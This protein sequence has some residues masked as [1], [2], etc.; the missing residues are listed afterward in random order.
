MH[1]K[2]WH[3]YQHFKDRTP[4]WIKLYRYL[5]DDPEWHELSGNSAKILVMLWLVAS[6]DKDRSGNLPC[7]KKLAFRLRVTEQSLSKTLQEL[8]H[9]VVQDDIKMIS[10]RYQVDAL[11][12]RR[13]RGETEE[14]REEK[15]EK[16]KSKRKY[17]IFEN[18]LLT[19]DEYQKIQSQ[20]PDCDERIENL[21]EG[22]ESKG[23]KYKSHYATILAWS[24]NEKKNNNRS[25]H[26]ATRSRWAAE[27]LESESGN[28]SNEALEYQVQG[29]KT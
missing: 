16:K 29:S 21:S 15:R 22:I 19:D 6:E 20:F 2:N 27:L 7:L 4:P 12:E 25:N 28:G 23:Y 13:D 24:R 18:V 1:I 3:E 9:W 10:G 11:E 8:S 14:R 17:G 26:D 5:L